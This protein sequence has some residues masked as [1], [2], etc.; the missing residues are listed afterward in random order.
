MWSAFMKKIGGL[1]LA[2]VFLALL[3]N[4]AIAARRIVQMTIPGCF[5]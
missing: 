3:A 1:F 5:S 2:F 4:P